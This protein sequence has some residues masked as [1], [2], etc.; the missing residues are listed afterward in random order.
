[1][2]TLCARSS[3][4]SCETA[5]ATATSPSAAAKPTT[6]WK[7]SHRPGLTANVRGIE[8]L[9]FI[10]RLPRGGTGNPASIRARRRPPEKDSVLPPAPP[11]GLLGGSSIAPAG[12]RPAG[13]F[14]FAA[15]ALKPL[16][17]GRGRDPRAKRA[18]E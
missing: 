6:F 14:V 9:R 5:Q 2:S 4:A 11:S 10:A 17:L 13:V 12:L 7:L 8:G 16:S 3:S 18:G 1:M 15:A